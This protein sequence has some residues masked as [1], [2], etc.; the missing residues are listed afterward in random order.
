MPRI[1][2]ASVPAGFAG[3]GGGADA[4]AGVVLGEHPARVAV[5]DT[6]AMRT[7]PGFMACAPCRLRIRGYGATS[8]PHTAPLVERAD[9]VG[10]LEGRRIGRRLKTELA[11]K[12]VDGLDMLP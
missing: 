3:G 5:S 11:A 1:T 7:N 12:L 4:A 8:V 2:C 10:A 9:V 6:I